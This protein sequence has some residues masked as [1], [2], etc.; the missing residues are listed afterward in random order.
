MTIRRALF[1]G[2]FFAT[3]PA[4]A[5]TSFDLVH[6]QEEFEH[7]GAGAVPHTW[8]REAQPLAELDWRY[9]DDENW[10]TLRALVSGDDEIRAFRSPDR[11][12]SSYEMLEGLMLVRQGRIVG[13]ALLSTDRR[14]ITT[15]VLPKSAFAKPSPA[16]SAPPKQVSKKNRAD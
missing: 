15:L 5:Y 10:K 4:V 7:F 11:K 14:H 12:W 6:V 9:K 2:L 13:H 16:P 3:M 1:W 8:W